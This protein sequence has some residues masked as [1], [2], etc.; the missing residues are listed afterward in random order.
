MVDLAF[1]E[2]I[3][4]ITSDRDRIIGIFAI[5]L[6]VAIFATGAMATVYLNQSKSVILNSLVTS[7]VCNTYQPYLITSVIG[8]FQGDPL[9]HIA[10][11]QIAQFNPL[12]LVAW[13]A[14]VLGIVLLTIFIFESVTHMG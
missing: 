6:L 4:A 1:R 14:E 8:S 3:D 7:G 9:A 5:P 11:C 13:Y 2:T 10:M 12:I